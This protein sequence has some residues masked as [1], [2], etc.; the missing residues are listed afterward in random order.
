MEPSLK[1]VS[2]SNFTAKRMAAGTESKQNLQKAPAQAELT[3]LVW[4]KIQKK[5]TKWHTM[6][7]QIITR[8]RT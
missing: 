7:I 5:D 8:T 4:K 2:S 3:S 6:T 1:A